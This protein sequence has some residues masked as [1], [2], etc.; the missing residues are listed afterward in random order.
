MKRKLLLLVIV[1]G[2]L[3]FLSV[4]GFGKSKQPESIIYRLVWFELQVAPLSYRFAI[5][6]EQPILIGFEGEDGEKGATMLIRYEHVPNVYERT[7]ER[8]DNLVKKSGILTLRPTK[9]DQAFADFAMDSPSV[10]IRLAYADDTRWASVYDLNNIPEEVTRLIKDTKLLA[11]QI[12]REQSKQTINVDTAQEYLKQEKNTAQ[13]DSPSIIVKVKVHKSGKISANGNEVTFSELCSI[14]DDLKQKNGEVWY[15]REA[16]DKE[17]SESLLK[18][19]KQV[20]DA[21]TS[22]E[23]PVHLQPDEY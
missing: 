21:I 22:R 2:V 4:F 7:V 3:M 18:T 1:L 19:I 9:P 8:V 6:P 13:K 14:L 5:I 16:P 23:L 12:M 10:H 17:P 11:K 15:F 20:L